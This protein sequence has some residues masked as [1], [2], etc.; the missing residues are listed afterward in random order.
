M[1]VFGMGFTDGLQIIW[2]VK[3]P[4]GSFS[5]NFL[6]ACI[7]FV[8]AVYSLSSFNL[9]CT[10]NHEQNHQPLAIMIF[11]SFPGI[12]VT[13]KLKVTKMYNSYHS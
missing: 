9:N 11:R 2:Y 7:C 10:L 1:K 13:L 5:I 4:N 3:H 12:F 8:I 6:V